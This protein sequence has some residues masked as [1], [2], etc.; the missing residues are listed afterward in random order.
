MLISES[1]LREWATLPVDTT[2]LSHHL[3][4]A[5]LEV[6]TVEPVAQLG[7]L[8]VV[9][10]VV[11]MEPH[12]G[13]DKLNVCTVNIGKADALTIVCGAPNAAKGIKAPV[14][15][16]SAELPGGM[17]IESRAVRGVASNGM[18]CSA[19]ELAM[20]EQSDGLM[21]LDSEA[22]VGVTVDEYLQLDDHCIDVDLTPDR[23]DC[24]SIAGVAREMAVATGGIY[25]PLNISEIAPQ[26]NAVRAVNLDAPKDCPKFV[27]RIIK[28]INPAA[29]TPDWMREKLRRVGLR[30]IDPVV[31]VTNYVM[32]ELG[33]PM[34]AFDADKLTGGIRVRRA[35]RGESLTLLNE[36]TVVLD[37]DMLLVTDQTG[38]VALAGIMGGANSAIGPDSTSLMLEAAHFTPQAI[39]GRARRLG[40]HTDASHRFERG[41]DPG[42][43]ERAIA[44]ASEL[45]QQIVGGEFG[46]V[47]KSVEE[48]H[49]SQAEPIP[50]RARKVESLLGMAVDSDEIERILTGLGMVLRRDEANFHVTAPSWRFDIEGEHDLIEEVGRTVG[51]DKIAPRPPRLLTSPANASEQMVSP[52]EVKQFFAAANYHEVVSYSFVDP[53]SEAA[54]FPERGGIVLANPIAANMAHMRT[55]IWVGLLN[56]AKSN[57]QRQHTR[58]RLFEMGNVFSEDTSSDTGSAEKQKLALLLSGPRDS[59][60][61]ESDTNPVNFY[62][63]KGDLERL[64]AQLGLAGRVTYQNTDLDVFH[65]GQAAAVFLDEGPIGLIGSL[66]PQ[67]QTQFD[68][69]HPVY[70]AEIDLKAISECALPAFKEIS[71][72]S[73]STRDLAIVLDEKIAAQ[74]IVREIEQIAGNLLKKCVI[75]DTYIGEGVGVGKKSLAVS[76]TLQSDSDSVSAQQ[77]DEL[78]SSILSVLKQKYKAQLRV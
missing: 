59:L 46:A 42:L 12:P 60:H 47:F 70:L 72:F 7:S 8:L 41:V 26:N 56:A 57:Q 22:P 74:Q 27:G 43:P 21:L 54:L 69:L 10:E 2:Q 44:R 16:V 3:T 24:L 49:L 75:F 55:S 1:W 78:T 45:L 11:A 4:Q 64:F 31:D 76:L 28:N 52:L 32:M 39:V 33:Q 9:G 36:Q 19:S 61:W 77:A 20:E 40:L 63:L 17:K 68:L 25:A 62:H 18:L 23:G 15:L 51:L 58:L 35:E 53:A 13:A 73:A 65:P 50:L 67:L 5:G 29:Q 34:H 14:A 66:H 71:R 37:P 38:P 6:E 30:S 48:M